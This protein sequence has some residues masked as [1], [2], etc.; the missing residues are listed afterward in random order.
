MLEKYLEQLA[1]Y[2]EKIQN[3]NF[4]L[5]MIYWDMETEKGFPSKGI[6]KTGKVI[7]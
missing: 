6:E 1:S 7:E 2:N 4:C 3:Y 5:N